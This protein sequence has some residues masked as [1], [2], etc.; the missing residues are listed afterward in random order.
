MTA[1]SGFDTAGKGYAARSGAFCPH[2]SG[3]AQETFEEYA[4]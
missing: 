2:R 4:A 1:F 3:T